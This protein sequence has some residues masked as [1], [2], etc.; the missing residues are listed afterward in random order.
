MDQ[1]RGSLHTP[2]IIYTTDRRNII[3]DPYMLGIKEIVV[4]IYNYGIFPSFLHITAIQTIN[5]SGTITDIIPD[6]WLN[7]QYI[8]TRFL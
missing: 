2:N 5:V 3:R 6:I 1:L 4:D 8:K 7:S